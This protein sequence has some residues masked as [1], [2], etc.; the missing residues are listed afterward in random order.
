VSDITVTARAVRVVAITFALLLSAAGG[1]YAQCELPSRSDEARLLA[2]YSGPIAFSPFRTPEVLEPAAIVAG[3]ELVLIP[4]P[5][6]ELSGTGTCFTRQS[7]QADL[8]PSFVRPR[9]TFGLARGLELEASYV[10]PIRISGTEPNIASAA[11]SWTRPLRSSWTGGAPRVMVRAHG[12]V[13]RVRGAITCPSSELQQSNPAAPCYGSR[14]SRDT[15]EPNMFGLEAAAAWETVITGLAG[16]AGVGVNWLRPRFQVGFTDAN[17]TV[18]T[19][20]VFVDLTRFVVFTG[21]T[22]HAA[23]PFEVSAQVYSVPEDVTAFRIAGA[24]KFR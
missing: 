8:A 1:L 2:F 21:V 11:L 20:R 22:W 10:P 4:N 19:T 13:G 23:R 15:F 12:T 17:G 9:F 3:L 7:P 6:E 14:E 18:D 5:S 24:Y 16:Y